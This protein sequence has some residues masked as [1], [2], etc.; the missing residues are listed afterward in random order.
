MQRPCPA[1]ATRLLLHVSL[2]ASCWLLEECTSS[3]S[4]SAHATRAEGKYEWHNIS[5]PKATAVATVRDAADSGKYDVF[6]NLCD[7][8][9][10]EDR[11]GI[12]VVQALER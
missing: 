7:G 9:F 1:C 4:P 10:D 8:A 11:A 2:R 3:T 5:V 6:L 12:E